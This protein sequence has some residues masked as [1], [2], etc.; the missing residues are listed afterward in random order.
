MFAECKQAA[1]AS[2][3]SSHL[4]LAAF[5]ALVDEVREVEHEALQE[6]HEGHPL[7]VRLHVD[8]LRRPGGGPLP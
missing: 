3:T 7:V 4:N 1:A 2:A 8:V 5:E 6:E